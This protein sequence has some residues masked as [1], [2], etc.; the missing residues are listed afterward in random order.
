MKRSMT[1]VLSSALLVGLLATPSFAEAQFED[2]Q[3]IEEGSTIDERAENQGT[4]LEPV[5]TSPWRGRLWAELG[6]MNRDDIKVLTPLFALDYRP[7]GVFQLEAR[8]GLA[9][10]IVDVLGGT[11]THFEPGNPYIAGYYVGEF[12]SWPN[13][14]EFHLGLGFAIPVAAVDDG[15][16]EDAFVSLA[17]LTG[18]AGI[19]GARSLWLWAPDTA[20]PVLSAR[21]RGG[22]DEL[23]F[24]ANVE[25]ALFIPTANTDARD[26]ESAL[27]LGVEAGYQPVEAVVFGLGL[28]AVAFPASDSFDDQFQAALDLFVRA[29]PG[30]A[31]LEA[32][33]TMNLDDPFGFAFD[34]EGY[35]GLHIGLGIYLP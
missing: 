30:G 14:F 27:E 11:E 9:G 4:E 29:S 34:D 6:F 18:A 32:T 31:L 26:L 33:F 19:H 12:G 17:T 21:L 15:S 24:N 13:E 3:R 35:W 20:T 2:W 8:F 7:A 22:W 5:A 23:R 1:P 28:S 16:T 25:Y 10:A